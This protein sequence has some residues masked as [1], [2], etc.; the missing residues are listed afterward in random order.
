MALRCLEHSNTAE[1]REERR[2]EEREKR[3]ERRGERDIDQ[4]DSG[5][6]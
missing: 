5:P 1:D 4:I 6:G 3:R 2:G